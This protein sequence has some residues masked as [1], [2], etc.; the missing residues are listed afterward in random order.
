MIDDNELR[1]GKSIERSDLFRRLAHNNSNDH[2]IL[3]RNKTYDKQV[4][5]I[6]L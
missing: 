6:E 2:I 3:L 1:D 5:H 4:P